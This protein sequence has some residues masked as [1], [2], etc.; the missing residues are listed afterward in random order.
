ML[1]YRR[2][3]HL[4]IIGY[5]DSNFSGCLESRRSTSGYIYILA[6]DSVSLR[7]AKQTI[8]ASSTMVVEYDA[9]YVASN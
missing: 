4:E 3:G 5:S 8:I 2:S 9:C 1:T 6:S 7:R